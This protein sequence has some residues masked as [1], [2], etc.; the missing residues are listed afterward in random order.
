[1]RRYLVI[2]PPIQP[3]HQEN[4][5]R[6]GGKLGQAFLHPLKTYAGGNYFI[7][8][9]GVVPYFQPFGAPG[10]KPLMP[11]VI[12]ADIYGSAHQK[13]RRIVHLMVCAI[14]VQAKI[15]RLEKILGIA[16]VVGLARNLSQETFPSRFI[17]RHFRHKEPPPQVDAEGNWRSGK[18][19][20]RIFS[21]FVRV[22]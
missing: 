2:A 8:Q 18:C 20:G 16:T 21:R 3:A 9:G 4:F 12:D 1:M 6:Q 10:R 11:E 19:P 5:P 22:F 17:N 7:L 13:R 14:I 15:S